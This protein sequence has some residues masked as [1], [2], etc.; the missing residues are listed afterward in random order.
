QDSKICDPCESQQHGSAFSATRLAVEKDDDVGP[1]RSTTADDERV[2][3]LGRS[4]HVGSIDK[5]SPH[6]VDGSWHTSRW[7]KRVP[8]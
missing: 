3:G 7:M 6:N 5:S 4:R 2:P 1:P 8:D